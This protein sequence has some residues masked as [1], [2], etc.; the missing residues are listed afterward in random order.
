M[1]GTSR[2]FSIFSVATGL[3][4]SCSSVL[5]S[6]IDDVR[7]RVYTGIHVSSSAVN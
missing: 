5:E 7:V 3:L 2:D 1:C 6:C 4:C